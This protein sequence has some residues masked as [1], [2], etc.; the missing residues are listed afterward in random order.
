MHLVRNRPGADVLRGSTPSH[1]CSAQHRIAHSPE[2]IRLG[3]IPVDVSPTSPLFTLNP[4]LKLRE[5][6]KVVHLTVTVGGLH[7][8]A[9]HGS[10]RSARACCTTTHP[11]YLGVAGADLLKMLLLASPH[12]PILSN[13]KRPR[14]LEVLDTGDKGEIN[15]GDVRI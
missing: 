14:S 5:H 4:G 9:D 2:Q 6:V 3:H 11:L 15:M 1:T 13:Q 10:S 8:T 7:P 12:V